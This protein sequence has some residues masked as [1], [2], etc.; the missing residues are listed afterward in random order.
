MTGKGSA[1][2]YMGLGAN[3]GDRRAN[4]LSAIGCL[5]AL[6]GIAVLR[7]A[8]LY[9]S[10]PVGFIDQPR[11]VNTVI[12]VTTDLSPFDLLAAVQRVER[13]LGRVR[14]VRW[15]PRTIDID[16]LLYDDVTM[17]DPALTIPHPRMA[18]RAF[19]LVPLA[20]LVPDRLL[21]GRTV[22]DLAAAARSRADVEILTPAAEVI[23]G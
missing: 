3:L 4:I 12:E 7:A 21:N 1:K 22:R 15:G 9:E 16:I 2:A 14:T 8:S 17:D 11:F 13:D 6:P 10:A 5:R 18:E 19:V 23:P 20:E